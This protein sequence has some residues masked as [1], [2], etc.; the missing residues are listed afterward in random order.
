VQAYREIREDGH[1][2]VVLAGCDLV[3]R[4]KARG[5]DNIRAIQHHLQ[6][7]ILRTTEE[8]DALSTLV[9]ASWL[10]KSIVIKH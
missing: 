10:P 4:L 9:V 8:R 6:R 5:L 3:H 2:V 7:P 1:P